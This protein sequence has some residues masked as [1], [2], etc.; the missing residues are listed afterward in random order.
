MPVM[1]QERKACLN[2]DLVE[3]QTELGVGAGVKGHLKQWQEE[4][5]Q[6]LTKVLEQVL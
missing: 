3:E 4:V 6:N 1:W 5:P 2:S